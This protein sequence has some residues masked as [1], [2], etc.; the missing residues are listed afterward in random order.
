[1]WFRPLCSFPDRQLSISHS[2]VASGLG[3]TFTWPVA[4][5]VTMQHNFQISTSVF[6]YA[7]ARK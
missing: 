7:K 6:S 1:V 2:R 5:Y 4:D 3:A